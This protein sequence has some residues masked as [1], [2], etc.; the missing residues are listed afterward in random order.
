METWKRRTENTVCNPLS[1][2]VLHH[3]L[4]IITRRLDREEITDLLKGWIK[5]SNAEKWTELVM[6]KAVSAEKSS[7]FRDV[8]EPCSQ[9]KWNQLQGRFSWHFLAMTMNRKDHT[10]TESF[11]IWPF[12]N[13]I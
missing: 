7:A 12:F 1:L 11:N 6:C 10:E 2:F 5:E 8:L 13:N 4:G 3:S 9:K